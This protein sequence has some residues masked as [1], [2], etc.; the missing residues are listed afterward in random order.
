MA[1]LGSVGTRS[2]PLLGYNF[3]VTLI[4]TSSVL[5]LATSFIGSAISDVALGGF[6]ECTGLE[7]AL[8]V[9]EYKEGGNN[10]A[11]LKFPTRVKWTDITLKK[12]MGTSTEL[13]DWHYGFVEGEGKRRDGII[14]LQNDLHEPNNIWY[15][16]RGLPIKYTGPTMNASQNGVA[17]ESIVIAHEGIYQVPAVGLAASI[18]SGVAS[19]F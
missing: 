15:F 16:K 10:G 18:V 13:W 2:D 17:I 5:A 19:L 12:G 1:L 8:D 3:I 7:M 6:T 14:M 9:E 11:I 4:D